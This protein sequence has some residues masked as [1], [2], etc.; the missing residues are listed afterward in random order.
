MELDSFFS[1]TAAFS[2]AAVAYF[3]RFSRDD[4]LEFYIP[5]I[6]SLFFF[7]TCLCVNFVYLQEKFVILFARS[8]SLCITLLTAEIIKW[9]KCAGMGLNGFHTR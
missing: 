1:L 8:K 3:L 4:W 2:V 5:D 6:N 9:Q 7:R